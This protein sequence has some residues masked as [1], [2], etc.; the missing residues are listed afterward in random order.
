MAMAAMIK[1]MA[2]TISSSMSENPFWLF[3]HCPYS[4][5]SQISSVSSSSAQRFQSGASMR[6]I[7]LTHH[8][9]LVPI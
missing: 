2:T 9:A 1:M 7:T 5:A 6:S 3:T 4:L 8:E